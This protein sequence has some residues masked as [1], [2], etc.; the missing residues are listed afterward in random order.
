[1][2][3]LSFECSKKSSDQLNCFACWNTFPSAV[4]IAGEYTGA[5]GAQLLTRPLLAITNP[6][7]I[8]PGR[9]GPNSN[10]DW[11]GLSFGSS[12]KCISLT[13]PCT[14]SDKPVKALLSP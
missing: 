10:T 7:C 13:A 11:R 8:D 6:D 2:G 14:K 3:A 5:G 12:V 9:G 4:F 1:M